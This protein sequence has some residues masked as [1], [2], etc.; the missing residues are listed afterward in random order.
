M[1]LTPGARRVIVS[2]SRTVTPNKASSVTV[3]LTAS[4]NETLHEVKPR[5][6]VAATFTV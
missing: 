1:T 3:T 6:A 4:G 2:A 5:R